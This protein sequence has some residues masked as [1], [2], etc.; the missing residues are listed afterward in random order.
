MDEISWR[1]QRLRRFA[2]IEL[3]TAIPLQAQAKDGSVTRENNTSLGSLARAA[4]VHTRGEFMLQFSQLRAALLGVVG[5]MQAGQAEPKAGIAEWPPIARNQAQT[6]SPADGTMS[7]LPQNRS[8]GNAIIEL[9]TR[10]S[11]HARLLCKN[12]LI[13]ISH[14]VF[15][16]R[17]FGTYPKLI[18]RLVA[19][20]VPEQHRRSHICGSA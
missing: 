2:G 11:N 1:K 19:N 9:F 18:I 12:F 10:S 20:P 7:K 5:S 3:T 4:Y 13:A 15:R 6:C 8:L 16:F 17:L 14:V